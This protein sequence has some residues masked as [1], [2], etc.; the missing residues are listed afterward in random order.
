M[1]T[2]IEEIKNLGSASTSGSGS[3]TKSKKNK[4]ALFAPNKS[5]LWSLF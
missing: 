1:T 2:T 5:E 3:G 4:S